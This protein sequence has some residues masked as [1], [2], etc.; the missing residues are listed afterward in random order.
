MKPLI[1]DEISRNLEKEN[2]PRV[3]INIKKIIENED[4]I[5]L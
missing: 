4:K 2:V 5:F 1:L 3:K